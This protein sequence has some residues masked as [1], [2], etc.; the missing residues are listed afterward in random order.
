MAEIEATDVIVSQFAS[1]PEAGVKCPKCSWRSWFSLGLN[2]KRES[3]MKGK[4]TN[5]GVDL[6]FHYE[7]SHWQKLED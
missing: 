6:T 3:T 5:C 7:I 1:T 2:S 4:C